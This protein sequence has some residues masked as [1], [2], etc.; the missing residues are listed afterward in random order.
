MAFGLLLQVLVGDILWLYNILW[1]YNIATKFDDGMAIRS[2]LKRHRA[3][4]PFMAPL[5]PTSPCIAHT[6][7]LDS[8]KH[9]S[10]QVTI[11]ASVGK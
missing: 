1:Q 3:V 11:S 6:L 10:L 5:K 4:G 7:N 2:P 9:R 8:Q